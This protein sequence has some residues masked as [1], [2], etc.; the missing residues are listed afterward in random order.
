MT[1]SF[2][3]AAGADPADALDVLA[4]LAD[5]RLASMRPRGQTPRMRAALYVD[6]GNNGVSL[7]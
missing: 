5:L 1:A 3:E 4:L 2:N 7:Q 6:H